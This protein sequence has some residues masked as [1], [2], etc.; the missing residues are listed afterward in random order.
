MEKV[1]DMK[2]WPGINIISLTKSFALKTLVFAVIWGFGYMNW[3]FVWLIFPIGFIVLAGEKKKAGY[4]RRLTAQATALSKDRIIVESRIDE[5]PSWVFFP[6]YSR[7]DWLN[8]VK[9]GLENQSFLISY[10]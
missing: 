5:L 1:K 10:P 4:L 8:E 9:I 7:V 3:S 2:T 6:D